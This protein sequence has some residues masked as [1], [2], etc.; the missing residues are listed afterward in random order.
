MAHRILVVEDEE[1]LRTCVVDLLGL[2][3][4]CTVESAPNYTEGVAKLRAGGWD[5]ILTD[6]R[7][8]DG[9]GVDIL[10]EASRQN[11]QTLLLLMSAFQ[12]FD[13]MMA[14]VNLAIIDHFF[15]KPFDPAQVV[16]WIGKA[17]GQPRVRGDPSRA[18]PFRRIG[19]AGE[20][21]VSSTR[22][23]RRV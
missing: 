16:Q 12:D 10:A 11:P 4:D 14:G 1:D 18:R 19:A 7:L 8:G 3:P 6:E 5:A 15:Q 20:G 9:R 13:A 21:A 17:I 2:V 22:S 23:I